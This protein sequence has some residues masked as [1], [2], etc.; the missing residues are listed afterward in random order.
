LHELQ[1]FSLDIFTKQWY[2]AELKKEA[3]S[4]MG[5]EDLQLLIKGIVFSLRQQKLLTKAESEYVLKIIG[6]KC[7]RPRI[8]G[9]DNEQ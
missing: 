7:P 6:R 9:K 4:T 5:K 8:T 3:E 1:R 2:Y